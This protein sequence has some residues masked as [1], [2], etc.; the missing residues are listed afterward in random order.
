MCH[1]S[2]R[3]PISL[4]AVT[5]SRA[6]EL[7]SEHPG[8]VAAAFLGHST[9]VANKHYW[10]VTD[11]DFERAIQGSSKATQN[12]TQHLHVSARTGS[13]GTSPA[14]EKTPLLPVH[15]PQCTNVLDGLV[16]DT[17]LEP[18]TSTV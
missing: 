14:D 4:A 8:Y 1:G 18:V 15:A 12:A 7:A 3:Q 5:A 11:E 13:P 6:T 2:T 17:G 9:A 10:Q 16:G